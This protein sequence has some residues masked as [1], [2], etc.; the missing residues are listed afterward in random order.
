MLD[1]LALH[2]ANRKTADR[3]HDASLVGIGRHDVCDTTSL[4]TIATQATA[5]GGSFSAR[6]SVDGE[7]NHEN[8]IVGHGCARNRHGSVGVRISA[9]G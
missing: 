8:C 7:D 4:R 6:R 9:D 3:E 2:T 1:L 5:Q